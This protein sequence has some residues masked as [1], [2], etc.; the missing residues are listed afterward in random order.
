[1]FLQRD[2]NPQIKN[3]LTNEG[4]AR[5]PVDDQSLLLDQVPLSDHDGSGLRDDPSL[6]VNDGPSSWNPE[7]NHYSSY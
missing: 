4:R 7:Q 1:M 6:R 3:I 2:T 5:S